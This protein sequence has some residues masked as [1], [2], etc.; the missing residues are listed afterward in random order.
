M[1]DFKQRQGQTCILERSLVVTWR[2]N[3]VEKF[4]CK[5]SENALFS[6][7]V[8]KNSSGRYGQSEWEFAINVVSIV[9]RKPSV[10]KHGQK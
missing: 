5:T 2:V 9:H 3:L 10:K 4:R 7:C 6:P 1:N 8:C